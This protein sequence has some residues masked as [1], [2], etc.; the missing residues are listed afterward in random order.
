MNRCVCSVIDCAHKARISC[1]C[2]LPDINLCHSHAESHIKS[3]HNFKRF[4]TKQ[5]L[6][7]KDGLI[8]R[9]IE[10][11]Q[12]LVTLKTRI[13]TKS[14]QKIK[15]IIDQTEK[16]IKLV[17]ED[18]K[19]CK[20][21]LKKVLETEKIPEINE[22]IYEGLIKIPIDEALSKLKGKLNLKCQKLLDKNS[23]NAQEASTFI[24]IFKSESNSMKQ[25]NLVTE[26]IKQIE[27]PLNEFVHHGTC[28]CVLPNNSLFCHGNKVETYKSKIDRYTGITFTIDSDNKATLLEPGSSSC[29]SGGVYYGGSVYVFGGYNKM[30][31][32]KAE[33]YDLKK[34]C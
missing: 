27:I 28:M 9:L 26:Q 20:L 25:I 4:L 8:E 30:I 6:Q 14:H 23:G 10:K 24:S 5:N 19:K 1:F 2:E 7:T 29:Y 15:E 16:A 11:T 31:L 12:E 3:S 21:F 33:N 17:A 18:Q 32:R 34:R 22:N 13:L